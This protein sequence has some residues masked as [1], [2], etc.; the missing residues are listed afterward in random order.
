MMAL[1]LKMIILASGKAG[2]AS[3][4][5]SAS[6]LPRERLRDWRP[7]FEYL[8]RFSSRCRVQPH[9]SGVDMKKVAYAKVGA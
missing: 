9:V 8:S 7:H 3:E 4:L 5:V 6:R 2:E 1:A